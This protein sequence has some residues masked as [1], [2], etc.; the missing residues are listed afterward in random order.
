MKI[1]RTV[2][3]TVVLVVS[4]LTAFAAG[5]GNTA[6]LIIDVR[7]E[8]EW[9]DGHLE[10]AVLIPHERIEQGISAVAPEKSTRIY[11]YCR[12]GRRTGIAEDVLKKAGYQDLINLGTMENAA[13]VLQ[14]AIVK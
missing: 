4:A 11:L 14:R 2:I 9:K 13:A 1:I 10:G 6:P 5:N 8:A 7:T 12:S 3:L